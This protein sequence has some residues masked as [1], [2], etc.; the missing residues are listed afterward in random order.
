MN[1]VVNNNIQTNSALT[2]RVDLIIPQEL[3]YLILDYLTEAGQ[4]YVATI[5]GQHKLLFT[6]YENRVI[7]N[8]TNELSQSIRWVEN[9]KPQLDAD[10]QISMDQLLVENKEFP[11]T[12]A[13]LRARINKIKT[14][15]IDLF[16]RSSNLEVEGL[17][18]FAKNVRAMALAL[19]DSAE[20][21]I[22]DYLELVEPDQA[23][24]LFVKHPRTPE[25]ELVLYLL[26]LDRIEEALDVFIPH[27][28]IGNGYSPKARDLI[29]KYIVSIEDVEVLEKVKQKIV[30]NL[31]LLS[32]QQS[33]L[34]PIIKGFIAQGDFKTALALKPE[35]TGYEDLFIYR[36][37]IFFGLMDEA[38]ALLKNEA[39]VI[40]RPHTYEEMVEGYIQNERIDQ[41]LF[42]IFQLETA[43]WLIE[44][45]RERYDTGEL[46]RIIVNAYVE[47]KNQAKALE[48]AKK[49]NNQLELEI[50]D[51]F[52]LQD[53]EKCIVSGRIK[54]AQDLFSKLRIANKLPSLNLIMNDSK[55]IQPDHHR[56]EQE[57]NFIFRVLVASNQ[58]NAAKNFII[59]EQENPRSLHYRSAVEI[60]LNRGF[61][62][63]A[64]SLIDALSDDAYIKELLLLKRV[65]LLHTQ[66]KVE[67]AIQAACKINIESVQTKALLRML[68]YILDGRPSSF[69]IITNEIPL[70]SEK[71]EQAQKIA[72]S[73]PNMKLRNQA[74]KRI[75][76]AI[77]KRE[78]WDNKHKISLDLGPFTQLLKANETI[79]EQLNNPPKTFFGRAVQTMKAV[80]KRI[81]AFIVSI[82]SFIVSIF[83]T[84]ASMPRNLYKRL[85]SLRYPIRQ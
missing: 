40:F 61:Y 69:G 11:K 42:F 82:F 30:A 33:F 21:V 1:L 58:I 22:S 34:H 79:V 17:P 20:F 4:R 32:Q 36:G 51:E 52:L 73:L 41:A 47:E 9:I 68:N 31:S 56:A 7:S 27:Y 16:K 67:E 23:V 66:N 25:E 85:I 54:E 78:A 49:V 70:R 83:L 5:D 72:Q 26:S 84:V 71:I 3:L 57:G 60:L 74:L 12:L 46:Y 62:N 6:Y 43:N 24:A 28:L 59:L 35:T 8:L 29:V 65:D 80:A 15:F 76:E 48:Y 37:F 18:N 75:K 38:Q 44:N 50:Q 39:G 63:E 45:R 77:D 13:E 55:S 53:V 10:H 14:Q 64:D 19:N 81:M 2:P